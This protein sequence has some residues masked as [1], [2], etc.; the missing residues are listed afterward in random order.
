M[1]KDAFA[2]K[3]NG[4][5]ITGVANICKF[6]GLLDVESIKLSDT[7][8]AILSS[9]FNEGENGYYKYID[10]LCTAMDQTKIFNDE[11]Y[12]VHVAEF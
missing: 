11:V 6:T 8:K 5:L 4:E 9:K 1:T 10:E 12:S 7:T 3:F 2:F